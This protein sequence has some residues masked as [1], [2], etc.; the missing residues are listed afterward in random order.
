MKSLFILILVM[1]FSS[2]FAQSDTS[3]VYTDKKFNVIDREKAELIL[4]AYQKDSASYIFATYTKD[5]VL[6]QKETYADAGLTIKHGVYIEYTHG[7]PSL[8]GLYL[9]NKKEGN[10]I[11]FDTLGNVTEM[12][13][14]QRDSLFGPSFSYWP[15]G[16]KRE[17]R[18]YTYKERK[19]QTTLFYENGNIA[20]KEIFSTKGTLTDSTYLDMDGKPTKRKN[21]KSPPEYPGGIEKFYFLLGRNVRYPMDAADKGIQG[22]VHVSFVIT[23]NG[24]IENI[25][26]ERKLY[27]SLD[28]EALRV[29]KLS[30]N[31]IPGKILGKPVRIKYNIPI[32]FSLVQ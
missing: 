32:R 17:E 23:E 19:V 25:R 1:I 3:V 13:A 6:I 20:I 30:A 24:A 31:W 21:I 7:K 22:N 11:S 14:Y 5:N 2:S 8:K 16:N 18:I 27:P 29:M 9:N 4:K 12:E 26:I 10:F 15:S 28:E